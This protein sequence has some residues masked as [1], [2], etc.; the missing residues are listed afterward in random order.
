MLTL[1]TKICTIFTCSNWSW[2]KIIRFKNLQL[3]LLEIGTEQ[4]SVRLLQHPPG[5]VAQYGPGKS[6]A[7]PFT[8]ET[9]TNNNTLTPTKMFNFRN[10]SITVV[11]YDLFVFFKLFRT[12]SKLIC[13]WKNNT[14]INFFINDKLFTFKLK[15]SY[16]DHFDWGIT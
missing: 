11:V 1:I 8:F 3:H 16:R 12:L 6:L 9:I 10:R 14:K 15:L 7:C 5:R 2:A 13:E 4:E